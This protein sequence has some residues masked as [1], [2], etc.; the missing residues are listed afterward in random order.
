MANEKKSNS[1][2]LAKIL[3]MS[4]VTAEEIADKVGVC[5][6]T[7]SRWINTLGWKEMRAASSVTRPEL[8]NKILVS[9]SNLLDKANEIGDDETVAG[10]GDKLIKLANAIEKLEKKGSVVDCVEIMIDFENWLMKNRDLY[11]ELTPEITRL[12]NRL[13][14]DYLNEQFSG[15]K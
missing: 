11:S 8:I 14:N 1:Q 10:L 13:H 6:Q 5:R 4:G 12:V 15:R 9:I 7:V 3:Y 2:E